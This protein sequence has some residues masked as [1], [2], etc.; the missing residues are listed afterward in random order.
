MEILWLLVPLSL[1]LVSVIVGALLWAVK[2]GQFDDLEGPAHRILL[3]DEDGPCKDDHET[4]SPRETGA[5][6]TPT[7]ELRMTAKKTRSRTQDPQ[8]FD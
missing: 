3:D 5:P 7:Q 1:V 8:G 4:R 2:S 6:Q